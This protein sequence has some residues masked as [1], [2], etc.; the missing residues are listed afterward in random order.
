MY[1]RRFQGDFLLKAVDD[2]LL[3]TKLPPESIEI[4]ITEN[5]TLNYEGAAETLQKLHEKRVGIAFDDF[6]TGY[7][8]LSYLTRF[9]L[10]RIKIDRSFVRK[11]I[12]DTDAAA[13]V[14]SLIVMAHNLG[15]EVIAE[16]VET[17]AQAEFLLG[18][19]CEEAQ[20]FLYGAPV[21]A[22]D[23]EKYLRAR[24]LTNKTAHRLRRGSRRAAPGRRMPR[25]S[26]R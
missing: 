8:S 23:F 14:R 25:S 7:A 2:A 19:G 17:E 16:G 5:S 26:K 21:S 4:E 22:A 15:L 3:E 10:S 6:G 12:D 13:I 24:Q 9:P 11:I 20:G 18:E 1:S